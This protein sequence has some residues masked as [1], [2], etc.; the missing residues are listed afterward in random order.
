MAKIPERVLNNGVVMPAI[1]FGTWNLTGREGEE[2]VLEALKTGY[3]L[4][5]TAKIYQNEEE[6]GRA[7]KSSGIPREETFVTTKL[8]PND[9]DRTREAFEESLERLNLDYIDLYLIHWPRDDANKRRQAWEILMEIYDEG[10]VKAIGVSNFNVIQLDE[11]L[12]DRATPLAVN[13][14]EFHPF[15]YQDQDET[16]RFSQREEIVLEAYSPLAR[17][18]F[19]NAEEI[20]EV[21]KKLGKTNAQ[22]MIRWAIQHGTVPIPKSVHAKR[23]KKN[24][25]VFDFEIPEQDMKELDSLG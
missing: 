12:A 10:L 3:R 1:G 17:G 5:D 19:I 22:I 8:W 14:I 25:E 11:L 24:F 20:T 13:Q 4:I 9:F 15:I 23:I 2:A 16:L 21:A 18:G 7:I 6:I